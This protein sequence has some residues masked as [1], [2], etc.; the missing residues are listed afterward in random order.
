MKRILLYFLLFIS[1]NAY[2]QNTTLKETVLEPDTKDP[3]IG[4][5]ITI[6]GKLVGTTTD[7]K[8]NFTLSKPAKLPPTFRRTL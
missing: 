5:N 1:F 4:A 8:G 6:K 7:I 2:A 3:V